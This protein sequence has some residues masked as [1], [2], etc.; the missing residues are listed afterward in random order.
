M[1]TKAA[2]TKP[3]AVVATNRP[4]VAP[5]K[6]LL[7][8]TPRRVRITRHRALT[9]NL[10]ALIRHPRAPIHRLPARRRLPQATALAA[11]RRMAE[12]EAV[13]PHTVAEAVGDRTVEAAVTAATTNFLS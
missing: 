12:V 7:A 10:R 5:T 8:R 9:P 11:A 3:I 6:P 4:A 13:V 1:Q 2:G